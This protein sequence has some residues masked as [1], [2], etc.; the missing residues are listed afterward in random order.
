MLGSNEEGAGGWTKP[1]VVDLTSRGLTGLSADHHTLTQ[2]TERLIVS[3]NQLESLDPI[4]KACPNL[5]YLVADNNRIVS[6]ADVQRLAKLRNLVSVSFVDNPITIRHGYRSFVITL[7]PE[8][9]VLDGIPVTREERGSAAGQCRQNLGN[10]KGL[11]KN[12]THLTYF[13][14]IIEDLQALMNSSGNSMDVL[15]ELKV[16]NFKTLLDKVILKLDPSLPKLEDEW[17]IGIIEDLELLANDLKDQG[18]EPEKIMDRAFLELWKLQL[19]KLEELKTK[20]HALISEYNSLI[21]SVPRKQV[22]LV[23][24]T[25][26]RVSTFPKPERTTENSQFSS[27]SGNKRGFFSSGQQ[28]GRSAQQRAPNFIT[29]DNPSSKQSPS[30]AMSIKERRVGSPDA[31]QKLD[32]LTRE[33]Q[34]KDSEISNLMAQHLDA[35]GSLRKLDEAIVELREKQH[36]MRKLEEIRAKLNQ[37]VTRLEP[38][39]GELER[40]NSKAQGLE[41]QIAMLTE[42]ISLLQGEIKAC[43]ELEANQEMA[44]DLRYFHLKTKF[45]QSVRA[46]LHLKRQESVADEFREFK[47]QSKLVNS[48]KQAAYLERQFKKYG[49]KL[50][51]SM[52]KE[53]DDDMK[54]KKIAEKFQEQRATKWRRFYFSILEEYAAERLQEESLKK[55]AN[56]FNAQSLKAKALKSFKGTMNMYYG[57]PKTSEKLYQVVVLPKIEHKKLQQAWTA[58]KDIFQSELRPLHLKRKAVTSKLSVLKKTSILRAWRDSVESNK[59]KLS[60][61]RDIREELSLKNKFKYWLK[62]TRRLQHKQTW[63]GRKLAAMRLKHTFQGFCQGVS[64]SI[65]DKAAEQREAMREQAEREKL[66]QALEGGSTERSRVQEGAV[67]QFRE[68]WVKKHLFDS[69]KLAAS[70]SKSARSAF[71]KLEELAVKNTLR[72][73]LDNIASAKKEAESRKVIE[74]GLPDLKAKLKAHRK[75]LM[76]QL[77]REAA[78]KLAHQKF[79]V[80]VI[81]GST[82]L[83]LLRKSLRSLKKERLTSLREGIRKA[84][85]TT[86]LLQDRSHRDQQ[87]KTRIINENSFLLNELALIEQNE[88][89]KRMAVDESRHSNR[90]IQE[91]VA[92]LAVKIELTEKEIADIQKNFEKSKFELE[93][94][95]EERKL[96]SMMLKRQLQDALEEIKDL[97]TKLEGIYQ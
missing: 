23:E 46:F 75:L 26:Q 42:E 54:E 86:L 12:K 63:V 56:K 1:N 43:L 58:W 47:Q 18:E 32:L 73:S 14:R 33:C 90:K 65:Q 60:K 5:A 52:S 41:N 45:F 93:N 24:S 38:S 4:D 85:K 84:E 72:D 29:H 91:S 62:L 66:T 3:N 7:L 96:K 74:E 13:K 9:Q 88:A 25:K 39:Q 83:N 49:D 30:P 16:V 48:W 51:I 37:E 17:S 31:Q 11:I 36:S 77:W 20:V 67:E 27:N 95:L 69:I 55:M 68:K 61:L 71:E 97:D 59:V 79:K 8:L 19:A 28:S 81:Q 50:D 15:N 35:E 89:G 2:N 40:L 57:D 76:L 92:T 44:D 70:G 82:R 22:S 6:L 21:E 10:L 53:W 87:N 78:R 34:S 64:Q 94:D 80:E